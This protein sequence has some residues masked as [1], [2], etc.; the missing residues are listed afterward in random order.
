VLTLPQRFCSLLV[1]T[2]FSDDHAWEGLTEAAQRESAD[3]FQADLAPVSDPA[4]DGASWPAVREA[5]P[6]GRERA[7][8]LFIADGPAI[9]T[10]DHPILVVYLRPGTEAP[11]RCIPSELW[12]VDN[13]ISLANLDWADFTG[14]LDDDGVFRGF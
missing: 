11:F 8:V 6:Q 4:F 1:R 7:A 5:V 14:A 10:A 9:A 3:G 13:N 2:D 12:A